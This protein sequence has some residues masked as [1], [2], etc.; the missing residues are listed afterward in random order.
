MLASTAGSPIFTTQ[1]QDETV[2]VGQT[3]T[4]TAVATGSP[5]YQWLDNGTPLPG[6]TQSTLTLP[7]VDA[8][9]AGV[10]SVIAT[11]SGGPAF[12]LNATL[13]VVNAVNAPAITAQPAAQTANTGSTVVFRAAATGNPAPT[14]QWYFNGGVVPGATST[15]LV[16]P[17]VAAGNAGLY[18]C[19]ASNTGG[20]TSSNQ[21]LLSVITTGDPG[22]LITLS[23]LNQA[24]TGQV[25]TVGFVTGGAG[26]AG[27][28]EPRP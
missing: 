14:F 12:S 9:T 10:Y 1:P 25:L 21:A 19:L 22:R 6:A 5:T 17:A 20:G 15:T 24:G 11:N 7:N 26:T 27:S 28:Q 13:T 3:A 2:T 18:S 23:V 8:S 4:L 16:V